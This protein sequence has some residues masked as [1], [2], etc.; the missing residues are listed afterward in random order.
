[1]SENKQRLEIVTPQRKVFSEDV[2]FLVAP[3]VEGELGI[4]PN[5]APLITSLNIGIMRI[6]QDGKQFRT[7]VSGGFMEVRDSKVTVLA[8]A[9][10][11]TEEIDVARAEAA[12]KR[13]EDRIAAKDPDLDLIR[14]ELALKRSIM[15][16][17]AASEK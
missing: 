9:A 10:E 5:H 12:R 1:M 16:L 4:L 7:V 8:T 11:R 2:D 17:K 6:E 14:A 13:A 3:G 15:R